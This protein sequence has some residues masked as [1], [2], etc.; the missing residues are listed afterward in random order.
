MSEHPAS[1]QRGHWLS[2]LVRMFFAIAF[3]S[4][5]FLALKPQPVPEAFSQ[6]DKLYHFLAFGVLSGMMLLAWPR[7]RWW[8]VVLVLAMLGAGIDVLQ[9][10]EPNRQASLAD[11]L[12]DMAGVGAGLLP[13]LLLRRLLQ[14]HIRN[15]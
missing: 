6:A 2:L 15:A 3:S 9:S 13:G 1:Q 5:L 10:F 14:L 8:Q 7:M 11:W 12:A 4:I